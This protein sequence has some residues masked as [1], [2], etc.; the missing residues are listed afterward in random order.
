MSF[1]IRKKWGL[2]PQLV[3]ASSFY[4]YGSFLGYIDLTKLNLF[5]VEY[6]K[7]TLPFDYSYWEA[8]YDKKFNDV[9]TEE[10]ID[11]IITIN[12]LEI[13]D[14][15]LFSVYHYYHLELGYKALIR[16]IV[17]E[18][19]SGNYY[20]W[21]HKFIPCIEIKQLNNNPW[22][23]LDPWEDPQVNWKFSWKDFHNRSLS[24]FLIGLKL[25]YKYI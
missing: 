12:N 24:N 11:K 8:E 1:L 3:H 10:T 25:D 4:N 2:I 19:A 18:I 9:T 23:E 14:T 21:F 5:Y 22:S 6:I 13:K 16:Y 17:E 7:E 20:I 15:K